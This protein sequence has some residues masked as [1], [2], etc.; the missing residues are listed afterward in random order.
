MYGMGVFSFL[1]IDKNT[2]G[3]QEELEETHNKT[4]GYKDN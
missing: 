2:R 1:W 3:K 4:K